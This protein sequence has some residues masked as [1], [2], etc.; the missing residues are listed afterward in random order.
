MQPTLDQR[1]AGLAPERLPRH[2]G[3]IMDGNGRWAETRG[4]TR[5]EGHQH[6]VRRVR[7]LIAFSSRLGIQYLTLYVFSLENWRRPKSEVRALML[8]LDSYL[9]EQIDSLVELNV[10]FRT[11]GNQEPLPGKLRRMLDS[12]QE[13]TRH[14]T[15]TTLIA[16]LSYS[17]RDEIVR[18]FRRLA[19]NGIRPEDLTEATISSA[20]DSAGLPDPDLIIRTSGELRLSNFLIWQAAYSELYFTDVHWPDF[21]EDAFLDALE[22]YS[23]RERRFGALPVHKT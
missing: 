7:D 1:V 21:D 17:G 8:L 15:G 10:R 18:A 14:C 3:V 11:C 23:N 22:D 12:A 6:G 2:V 5:I 13:R 9:R 20:L 16:A 4:L 19:E